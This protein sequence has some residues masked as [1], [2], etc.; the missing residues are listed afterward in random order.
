MKKGCTHK[1]VKKEKKETP[2]GGSFL[3]S[4]EKVQLSHLQARLGYRF[5]DVN[6]LI[7]ALT[8]RSYAFEH[9][10][11]AHNERLEFLGDA[12]LQLMM[13]SLVFCESPELPEGEMSFSRARLVREET[14][15]LI[16]QDLNLGL[17]LRLGHGER[18]AGGASRASI[19]ADA[20]EALLAAIYLD[21]QINLD[22]T[23]IERER[24]FSGWDFAALNALSEIFFPLI[25]P[26]VLKARRGEL[27]YDYKSKL[28][29]AVQAI[30]S[31]SDVD[32][33][34]IGQTGEAHCPV[35]EV[36]LIYKGKLL[37]KA[38][39]RNK[40]EATQRV[41]K[42]VLEQNLLTKTQSETV[43]N[44]SERESNA[45]DACVTEHQSREKGDPHSTLDQ[46]MEYP[47]HEI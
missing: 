10:G 42:L 37:A 27:V 24:G 41:S 2:Q 25:Y 39:G 9:S 19:L 43:A 40:K 7:L 8:H 38:F 28:L 1:P 46:K 20:I 3:S 16:A 31:L 34:V 18:L 45:T 44:E 21:L 22:L 4:A 35:F 23:Q 26:Y 15:A 29:E 47:N 5:R 33:D 11:C 6:K 13:S 14:L 32:F 36:A 12:L 30:G 17:S